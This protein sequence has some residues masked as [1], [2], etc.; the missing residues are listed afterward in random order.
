[1]VLV[2]RPQTQGPPHGES[3]TYE[4]RGPSPERP[5]LEVWSAAF[6]R[7]ERRPTWQEQ[8]RAEIR[9]R[10][11]MLPTSPNQRLHVTVFG[12]KYKSA[13]VENLG[14]YNID[15]TGA[16]FA[17]AAQFGLSFE[18]GSNSSPSPSGV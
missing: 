9:A 11:H 18:S 8:L 1:M 14:L 17:R 7:F 12:A 4:I 13:D 5:L 10:V 2:D 3:L 15:D 16:A 6:I